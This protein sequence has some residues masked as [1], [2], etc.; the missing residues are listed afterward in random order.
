MS[1]DKI[2]M[3][4]TPRGHAAYA[5][6]AKK[7][8]K[9]NKGGVFKVTLVLDKEEIPVGRQDWGKK[10]V[11][12]KQW[13]KDLIALGVEHG[14]G[15]FGEA[16]CPV[17]DGN[18]TGKEEFQGKLLI[19]FKSTFKPKMLDTKQNPLPGSLTV[20]SGDDI[21]VL[22]KVKPQTVTD[23]VKNAD[24]TIENVATTYLSCY[25]NSVMLCAKNSSG[26]DMFG[27]DEEGFVVS[28]AE[29]EAAANFGS[30]EDDVAGDAPVDQG[31]DF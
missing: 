23:K 12:G 22:F 25:M 30:D 9:F 27:D 24:G 6:L 17:K 3:Q 14:A 7:D 15:K 29:R 10:Q 1:D 4:V 19:P 13:V 31:G 2:P 11:P 18:K 21:K 8:T 5:W 26:N 16:N 28:D 20:F